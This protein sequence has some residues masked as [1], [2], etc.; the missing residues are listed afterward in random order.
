MAAPPEA[1]DPAAMPTTF[2]EL[3]VQVEE[4]AEAASRLRFSA[5]PAASAEDAMAAEFDR[6]IEA[7][8][9]DYR[10]RVAALH[11][12]LDAILQGR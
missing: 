9:P 11:D 5:A 12:R 8:I 2:V 10:H 6:M 7:A 3:D 1:P 4:F